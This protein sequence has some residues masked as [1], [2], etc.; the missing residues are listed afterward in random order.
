MCEFSTLS[1]QNTCI[2]SLNDASSGFLVFASLMMML[3]T[4]QQSAIQASPRSQVVR[5]SLIGGVAGF[6][7][8]LLGVGG[9]SIIVPALVGTGLETKRAAATASFVIVFASL[10]G[11]LAHVTLS[12]IDVSL[13]GATAFASAAGAA[14]GAWLM[15]E[16]LKSGQLKYLIVFVLLGTAVK[17]VWGLL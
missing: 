10:T 6:V 12:G 2:F 16:K 8:G 15:S 11:F 4:P 1:G 14:L 5:G 9:G 13:L 7:G 3:Y 17:M